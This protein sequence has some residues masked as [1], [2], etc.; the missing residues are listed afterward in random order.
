M[1]RKWIRCKSRSRVKDQCSAENP[2]GVRN[3]NCRGGASLG[4]E[5]LESRIRDR[6]G[7]DILYV[8]PPG[9][10]NWII[11]DRN[12]WGGVGVGVSLGA[13]LSRVESGTSA[14]TLGLSPSKPQ[15]ASTSRKTLPVSGPQEGLT[16]EVPTSGPQEA[17]T[18]RE[19]CSRIQ[20]A[21]TWEVATSGLQAALTWEA[22][23]FGPQEALT[24]EAA[25]SGRQEASTWKAASS[26]NGD[27]SMRHLEQLE[28]WCGQDPRV[29][30]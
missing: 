8:D 24:W 6:R 28:H 1:G 27:I 10:R 15:E 7:S 26:R 25:S 16:W 22:A 12:R 5:L 2:L 18:W 4:G 11:E 9:G 14:G 20:A 30:Q 29:E 23:S 19:A 21:P 3:R 17:S 13:D